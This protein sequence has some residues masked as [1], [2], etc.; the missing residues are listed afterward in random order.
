MWPAQQRGQSHLTKTRGKDQGQVGL[1]L[2]QSRLTSTVTGTDKLRDQTRKDGDP[3]SSTPRQ[4]PERGPCAPML[5]VPWSGGGGGSRDH[6]LPAT[7]ETGCSQGAESLLERLDFGPDPR[8]PPP[9]PTAFPRPGPEIQFHS[10]VFSVSALQAH[11]S[12]G[13]RPRPVAESAASSALQE[14]GSEGQ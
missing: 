2:D 4:R 1:F 14:H 6:L 13:G 8:A 11:L 5:S 10:N 3:H 12:Y 9:G 7:P